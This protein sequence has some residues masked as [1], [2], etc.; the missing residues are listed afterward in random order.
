MTYNVGNGL[1]LPRRLAEV[2]RASE[3]DIVGLQELTADQEAG[4]RDELAEDYPYQLLHGAGIPGKGLLSRYPILEGG[5]IHSHP[6][7]P[8]LRATLDV[9]GYPLHVAVVH[10]APPRLVARG[11]QPS[12]HTRVQLERLISLLAHDLPLVLLGD[13]NMTRFQAQ[14]R[15]VA[16]AGLVDAFLAAGRGF[17]RTFPL[18]LGRIPLLP[19]LR[20]DYIWLSS[21]L[22]AVS[23]H[24]GPDAGSD[25]LPVLADVRW[26]AC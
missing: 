23:A 19:L 8:D 6:G 18:R 17:G 4:L 16:A 1:A 9:R 10:P 25:H 26:L 13:F 15:R 7:R 12:A 14:Y 24:V 11:L 2:V 22:E 21:H 3:A 5:Q 20:L